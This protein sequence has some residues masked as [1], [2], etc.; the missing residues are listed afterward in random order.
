MAVQQL[1]IDTQEEFQ[2]LVGRIMYT[3]ADNFVIFQLL[4]AETKSQLAVSGYCAD[5]EINDEV[6]VTGSWV[7]HEKYGK[8]IKASYIE[9]LAGKPLN[10]ARRFLSKTIKGIGPILADRIIDAFGEETF[11]I[12]EKQPEKL[13]TIKGITEEK[14]ADI[15]E[16]YNIVKASKNTMMFL[17]ALGLTPNT[18]MK[19]YM[20]Y[21]ENTIKQLKYD[22]YKTIQDV[23]QIGFKKADQL[24]VNIG[25]PRNS[26]KR[27]QAGIEHKLKEL[28]EFGHCAYEK[29]KL[30]KETAKL[31][32]LK[33]NYVLEVIEKSVIDKLLIAENDLIYLPAFFYAEKFISKKIINIVN[34]PIKHVLE[35]ETIVDI[36]KKEITDIELSDQQLETVIKTVNSKFTIITGGPGVGKTT[37]VNAIL[38]VFRSLSL[39]IGVAAPTGRAACRLT[40]TT[41]EI[42]KT[43]HRLLGYQPQFKCFEYDIDNQM[44][45]SVLVVDETS[46]LDLQMCYN[47]LQAVD[48]ETIVIFVGDKDQ[49]PSVGAGNILND[50]INSRTVNVCLL[51]EIFRQAKQSLIVTNAHKINNG[52]MPELVNA[53]D[54]RFINNTNPDECLNLI[55]TLVVEEIQALNLDFFNDVQILAPMK[56]G[57]CGVTALNKLLQSVLISTQGNKFATAEYTFYSGDKVMQRVNN[58]KKT[59]FNGDI[60][61][62]TVIDAAKKKFIVRM[63]LSQQDVEYDFSDANQLSLAYACS[64]HKSQGSEYP[65]VIIPVLT[66]HTFMLQ[67][68][69]LYTGITRGKKLVILVGSKKAVSVAVRSNKAERRITMLDQKLV[70]EKILVFEKKLLN[71]NTEVESTQ[72]PENECNLSTK[73]LLDI[74]EI[75]F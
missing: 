72:T 70:N 33:A 49:L 40:E 3:N 55:K 75:A 37:I 16:T 21:G 28:T 5:L 39:S 60:G 17:L 43:I 51:T 24:A 22:P 35:R 29:D 48:D 1:K 8:Q 19:I 44:P 36:I 52:E 54:F 62:I 31:L 6:K 13:K 32:E 14:L 59:V 38:K 25:I 11:D 56:K 57:V 53:R 30:A 74:E 9:R 50:I 67:K 69:L 10:E 12:I 65:C 18:A 68:N 2:G 45:Y 20:E 15:T 34:T 46:M 27:I 58:Y 4:V 71:S 64:I 7:N 42:A 26:A 61:R 47:L 73:D 66:E 41:G 63:T 23:D